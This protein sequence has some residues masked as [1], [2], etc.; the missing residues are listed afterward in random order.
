M[1]QF[2]IPMPH[3]GGGQPEPVGLNV[4]TPIN[5]IQLVAILAGMLLPRHAL[6]VGDGDPAEM[7]QRL[8]QQRSQAVDEAIELLG[9]ACFAQGIGKLPNTV[10]NALNQG[11]AAA[12]AIEE[13][14]REQ[15]RQEAVRQQLAGQEAGT[16]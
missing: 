13:A 15:V 9:H 16:Q 5:D 6:P 14:R 11:R 3:R 2:K 8:N 4:A 7:A 1:S 12:E 10:G